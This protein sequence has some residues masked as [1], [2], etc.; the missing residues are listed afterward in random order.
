[1]SKESRLRSILKAISWR[2]IATGTTFLLAYL[3]FSETGCEDVLEKSTIVAGL[4]MII[5]I[6]AYYFHERIWQIA[7]EGSI[8]RF[9]GVKVKED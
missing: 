5:K 2:I 9:F 1:M 3:V 7:P 6:I 4:E 8:R